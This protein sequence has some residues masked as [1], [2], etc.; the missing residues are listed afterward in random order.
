MDEKH[1]VDLF[2]GGIN[3][4]YYRH[5]EKQLFAQLEKLSSEYMSRKITGYQDQKDYEKE[6]Q[7]GQGMTHK[8]RDDIAQYPIQEAVHEPEQPDG[9]Q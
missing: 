2:G 5:P 1:F 7:A 9:D 8:K 3:T 4:L 6:A